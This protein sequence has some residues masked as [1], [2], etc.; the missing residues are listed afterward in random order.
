MNS[1]T[2]GSGKTDHTVPMPSLLAPYICYVN[3]VTRN[4]GQ[5]EGVRLLHEWLK[6]TKDFQ[7][8]EIREEFTE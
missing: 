1:N 5:Q 4:C 8:L 7:F 6:T 3:L 2:A